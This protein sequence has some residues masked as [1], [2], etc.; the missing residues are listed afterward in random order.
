MASLIG[1]RIVSTAKLAHYLLE[2][3]HP[4]GGSKARFFRAC[5]FSPDDLLA[6]ETAILLH[7]SAHPVYAERHHKHGVNRVIRCEMV[8]PDGRNPC[9]NTVWTQDHGATS[10]RFVTA[11]PA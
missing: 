9:V 1:V 7:A 10:Q 11:Y 2:V 6:F 3:S 4:A 5:G 8:T